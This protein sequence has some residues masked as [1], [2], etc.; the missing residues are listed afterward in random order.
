MKPQSKEKPNILKEIETGKFRGSY[1]IYNRKSTDEPDN[2]KN[3]I[4]YQ[5]SE[6]FRFA[7]RE[8]LPI[9]SLSIDGFCADGIISEKHSAF[10]E[11]TDLIIG[12]NGIVQYRIE[13][14]KFHRLI[15]FLNNGFFKGIIVL[16]WDR[17]SRN[18]G[19]E[20]I[21]RKLMKNGID[22]RFTLATY[23]KT[24]AGALHMDIDGMFAE[25]HSRVTSEKVSITIRTQREKGIC[26]YKAPVG[27]LNQGR[28]DH[29]PFDPLR[30]PI[31]KELFKLYA[32][33]KWTLADLAK[34]AI[35]QGFT[36]PPARRRRT[37]DEKL[38]EEEDDVQIN[39][40]PIT[41]LPTYTGIQKILINPFYTGKVLGNNGTYVRSRSHEPLISEELFNTVQ[42]ELRKKKVSAHYIDRLDHPLRGLIRC[43]ECMRLYTPYMKKGILYFGA[44]CPPGC[45]NTHRNFNIDFITSKIG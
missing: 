23:D 11:D 40:K 43:D 21:V 28:M 45:S 18:K 22:F 44:R 25:H 41:R 17:I 29:K 2:Q 16:C 4:K 12:E 3:S 32:T 15:N 42:K 1:L 9:A 20:T 39:I 33:G 8:H 5:K 35:H 26:T 34:W 36:M 7:V 10:K 6:N 19:D 14:P 31:I 37:T 27:Y 38:A 24:S 13:R 30:A